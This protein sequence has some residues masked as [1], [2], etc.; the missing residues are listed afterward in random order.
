MAD[1]FYLLILLYNRRR[2]GFFLCMLQADLYCV[3]V[4]NT[5]LEIVKNLSFQT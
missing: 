2:F 3:M 1:L 4:L 5:P